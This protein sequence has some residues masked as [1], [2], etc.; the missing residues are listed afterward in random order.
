MATL[1]TIVTEYI[2]LLDKP[3]DI[4]LY[5][6]IRQLVLDQRAFELEK[7]AKRYGID[8]SLIQYIDIAFNKVKDNMGLKID[9]NDRVLISKNKVLRSR[10]SISKESPFA[11]VGST[12]MDNPFLYINNK[13]SVKRFRSNK[14]FDRTPLYFIMDGYLVCIVKNGTETIKVG[15]TWYD[16]GQIDLLNGDIEDEYFDD[17]YEFLISLETLQVIKE[18]LLRGELGVLIPSDQEVKLEDD[19]RPKSTNQ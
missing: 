15:H 5:R 12:N 11:Y 19:E 17:T 1:K 14:Y 6:R 13:S 3:F 10:L 9:V 2:N 4:A 7:S 18:K 16:P 8:T